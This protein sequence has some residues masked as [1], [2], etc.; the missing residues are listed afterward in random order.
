M[1]NIA[2]QDVGYDLKALI[3]G[4]YRAFGKLWTLWVYT[5]FRCKLESSCW[6]STNI[7]CVQYIIHKHVKT[8][9]V[10]AN[11]AQQD[12]GYDLKARIDGSYRAFGKLNKYYNT[13]TKFRFRNALAQCRIII[14]HVRQ[15]R[16]I[17]TDMEVFGAILQLK[18]CA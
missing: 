10:L 8:L 11:I 12:V 7:L 1:V 4:S 14:L 18:Y 9:A 17:R 2:Q 6:K 3:D 16:K 5:S 15:K 13:K